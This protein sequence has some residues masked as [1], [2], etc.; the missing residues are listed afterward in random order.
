MP[1]T[2][3]TSVKDGSELRYATNNEAYEA[4]NSSYK[5]RTFEITDSQNNASITQYGYGADGYKQTIPKSPD[6]I[7]SLAQASEATKGKRF[8]TN[9]Q[10]SDISATTS[11]SIDHMGT[12]HDFQHMMDIIRKELYLPTS[13][14]SY[15]SQLNTLATRYNRFKLPNYDMEIKKGFAHVFFCRPQCRLIGEDGKLLPSVESTG[16]YADIFDTNSVLVKEICDEI[17]PHQSD[18]MYILSNYAKSF[19]LNDEELHSDTY[20]KTYTG[21]KISYG[22]TNIESKTA[23]S[24][25][26][27]YSDDRMLSIYKIHR[28]RTDYINDVYRGRLDPDVSNIVNKTLD[29]VGSVYYILTADD[30]ETILFWSKYYGVYPVSIPSSQYSWNS[31]NFVNPESITIQYNYSW[32]DD[33]KTDAIA[34]FNTNARLSNYQG[35]SLMYAP[36]FD[37]T[38]WHAGQTIVGTPYIERVFDTQM[39]EKSIYKLRFIPDEA[40]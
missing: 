16:S 22:K 12:S 7:E 20:G 8:D 10:M 31:G 2:Y 25:S 5:D 17:A 38:L 21:Y 36:T 34:E 28:L 39:T 35:N 27:T 3:Y 33:F 18:F 37:K 9:E 40:M 6:E 15:K 29:Y 23:G 30:N 13:S 26:V 14:F 4:G 1:I 24:F 19:S 11:T 32:K